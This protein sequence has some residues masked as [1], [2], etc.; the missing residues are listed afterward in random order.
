MLL[1]SSAQTVDSVAPKKRVRIH[2]LQHF[3]KYICQCKLLRTSWDAI[4]NHQVSKGRSEEHGGVE[5]RIYFIYKASYATFCKA[6]VWD[7]PPAFEEARPNRTGHQKKL[8]TVTASS[9]K[10]HIR[11]LLGKQHRQ[12]SPEPEVDN[13]PQPFTYRIPWTPEAFP[14]Q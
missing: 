14:L 4:Y 1:N 3:C 5:K 12:S 2:C 8:E 11:T 6:M 13:H 10:Q 9:T 7:D